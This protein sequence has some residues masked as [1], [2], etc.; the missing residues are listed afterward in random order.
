M[1]NVELATWK[2]KQNKI[3]K[4]KTQSKIFVALFYMYTYTQ[5]FLIYV[6]T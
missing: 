4:L 2:I 1:F 3:V 6:K 5:C